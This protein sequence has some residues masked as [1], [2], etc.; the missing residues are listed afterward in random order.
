MNPHSSMSG[1]GGDGVMRSA[2][3]QTQGNHAGRSMRSQGGWG[4]A[5]SK[6][7]IFCHVPNIQQLHPLQWLPPRL[8]PQLNGKGEWIIQHLTDTGFDFQAPPI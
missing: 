2:T 1:T 6:C 5:P 4:G 7:F 3:R 8:V